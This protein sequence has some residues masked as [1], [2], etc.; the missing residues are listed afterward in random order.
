MTYTLSIT[1]F[2]SFQTC[3]RYRTNIAIGK[4]RGRKE[5]E[6]ILDALERWKKGND[7]SPKTFDKLKYIHI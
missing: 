7:T 3:G 5:I 4:E 6:G 2:E 1:N